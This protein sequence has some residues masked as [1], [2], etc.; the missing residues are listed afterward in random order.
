MISKMIGIVVQIISSLW[1]PATCF[2][3]NSSP[4]LLLRL[5]RTAIVNVIATVPTTSNIIEIERT[6]KKNCCFPISPA[7]CKALKFSLPQPAKKIARTD[8]N[9]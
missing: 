2:G 9:I 5:F 4:T 3:T 8:I 1:L 7:G 6:I